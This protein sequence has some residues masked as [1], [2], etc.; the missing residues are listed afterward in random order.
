M[1]QRLDPVALGPGPPVPPAAVHWVARLPRS[2]AVRNQSW[3]P[4]MWRPPPLPCRGG[5]RLGGV[6]P[7]EPSDAQARS[8]PRAPAPHRLDRP[9][10]QRG[11]A[12][13]V[14]A[15]R[16]AGA[17]SDEDVAAL[18]GAALDLGIGYFAA[19]DSDDHG[20]AERLLGA[21][22]G[23]HRDEVTVATTFG[24]DT[25]PRPW[26]PPSTEPRHDWSADFAGR[27]LDGSLRRLR[28]EPVDLWLL[29]HP[30]PGRARVGRAVRVPGGPRSR[31]ERPPTTAWPSVPAPAGGTRARPPSR[32][33]RV[34]A[35]ET[36][37]NVAEQDPGRD[38]AAAGRRD[39]SRPGGARP[40]GPAAAAGGP[41]APLV[42]GAGPR[43]D[44][45]PG[46]AP[47]RPGRPGGGDRPAPGAGPRPP[48]RA[49]RGGRPAPPTPEDLDLLAE[50]PAEERR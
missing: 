17:R 2:R 42:P 24:Y 31:R 23:R 39:R 10:R 12:G 32:E 30:G 25:T 6:P 49:G 34:A 44:P 40:A 37:Y 16:R 50:L 19:T 9:R 3:P 36:V 20:R 28:L 14:A 11:R 18:L 35:V 29:H 13:G 43:P 46:A 4:M 22:L 15:G 21:A 1:D 27:A 33:R 47:L 48:G 38:L 45:R 26:D 41:R 8:L 7:S 5:R